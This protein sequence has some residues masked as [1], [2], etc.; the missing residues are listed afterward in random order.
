MKKFGLFSLAA[1]AVALLLFGVTRQAN[2]QAARI[3]GLTAYEYDCAILETFNPTFTGQMM[4]LRDYVHV[5]ILV[6][7]SPYLNGI[8]TT[9]ANAEINLKN[10]SAAIRGTMH[11]EPTAYP[12][13]AWDGQWVFVASK[14]ALFGRAVAQGSGELAGMTLFMDLTDAPV[15]DDAEVV[16]ATV[17]YD[18]YTGVPESSFT[19]V[20]GS[21][22]VSSR[23]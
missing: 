4:H 18:G 11:L 16:C 17:S 9:I 5:N 12:G 21:I 10:G 3:E 14:G 1:F 2:A 6:S 22:A 19:R 8:N 7:D 20:E 15:A 23:P 13:S